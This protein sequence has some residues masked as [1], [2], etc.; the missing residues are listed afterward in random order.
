MNVEFD[1]GEGA[2]ETVRLDACLVGP[3]GNIGHQAV[4]GRIGEVVVDQRIAGNVDL[5]R[6]LAMTVGADEEVNM[7]RALAVATERRKQLLR[8]AARRHAVAVRHNALK[9]VTAL[10]VGHDRATHIERCLHPGRVEVRIEAAGI[11]VP[12][13]DRRTFQRLAGG[14]IDGAVHDQRVTVGVAAV[15]ETGEAF[16]CRCAGD[17]K[18]PFDGARCRILDAE[19]LV[20]SVETFVEEVVEAE[21]GRDQAGLAGSTDFV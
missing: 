9:L 4:A 5:G 19:L 15:I 18:R 3:L 8:R 20:D 16:R 13:F 11:T 21:A 17:I 10:G 14:I 6:Q 12:D 7:R 2:G 1:L